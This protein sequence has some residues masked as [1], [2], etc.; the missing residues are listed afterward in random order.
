MS[1]RIRLKRFGT[2]KRPYYRVVV[3]DSRDSRDG[4][5]IEE[6]G[7]YHPIE[8][9]EKQVVLNEEKVKAWL[10]KGA[11]PSD[12]VHRLLNQKGIAL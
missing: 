5:A 8:A 7:Y 3:M 12:T 11:T 1:V 9:E 6:V 2:K 4:K 10:Q